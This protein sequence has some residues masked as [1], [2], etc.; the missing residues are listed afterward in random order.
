MEQDVRVKQLIEEGRKVLQR[1]QEAGHEAVFVG[2]FV[3]DTVLKRP[4]KD[5]DIATSALPEQVIALF[6]RTVPTGLQHGTVTV[7]MNGHSYEV[8]TYRKETA[9]TAFR[10]PETVEYISDLRED[11]QRRDFTMNAMAM[12]STGAVIDP[13]GGL[14]HLREGRL[15]CVGNPAERFGEDALRILRCARFAADYGLKVDPPTWEALLL[16]RPLLKH[17]AMERVRVEM[18]KLLEGRGPDYG[19]RLLADSRLLA[20]V[21]EPALPLDS[22]I[23]AGSPPLDQAVKEIPSAAGRWAYWLIRAGLHTSEVPDVLRRWTFSAAAAS[24]IVRV[25]RLHELLRETTGKQAS[26]SGGEDT[27][28]EAISTAFSLFAEPEQER[29]H[30]VQAVISCSPEAVKTWLEFPE[31]LRSEAGPSV[32]A[33]SAEWLK[34]MPVWEIRQLAIDGNQL[35]NR[36]NRSAGPWLK[37]VLEKLLV[38]T[39]LGIVPNETAALLD[40]VQT[41]YEMT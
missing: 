41:K 21:K 38:E 40:R 34:A 4:V 8:T 18:E 11:L 35:M 14:T 28:F 15:A 23:L 39:A 9:Y 7:L 27:A 22:S 24:R 30:F 16:Q 19:L 33:H 29:I 32:L 1:L 10:R 2:G 20:Y 31:A 5:I 26:S 25:M 13:F 37:Q 12:D 36:L 6:E 3:R 17:I